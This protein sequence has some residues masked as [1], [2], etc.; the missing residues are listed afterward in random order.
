LQSDSPICGNQFTLNW[1]VE[2]V[3]SDLTSLNPVKKPETTSLSTLVLFYGH[4]FNDNVVGLPSIDSE[5]V[6]NFPIDGCQKQLVAVAQ[7]SFFG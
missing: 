7:F 3:A 1:S 5:Q 4:S 6:V 2:N